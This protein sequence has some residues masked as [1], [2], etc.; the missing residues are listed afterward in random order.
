MWAHPSPE[1][2]N[3]GSERGANAEGL[4]V[5]SPSFV[6]HLQSPGLPDATTKAGS[7]T[8]HLRHSGVHPFELSSVDHIHGEFVGQF[9]SKLAH[10]FHLLIWTKAWSQPGDFGF[11]GG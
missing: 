9:R 10:H 2:P 5:T 1:N 7:A 8:E 6:Q 11:R 4:Q 3:S